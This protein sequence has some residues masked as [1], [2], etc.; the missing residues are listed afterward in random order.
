MEQFFLRAQPVFIQLAQ[1]VA[2]NTKALRKR[3]FV[4]TQNP[5]NSFLSRCGGFV[6]VAILQWLSR[7][8]RPDF[9]F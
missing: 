9:N 5:H 8:C 7:H 4:K 3:F 2:R 6:F 1:L